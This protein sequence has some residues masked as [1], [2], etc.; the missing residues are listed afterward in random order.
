[1]ARGHLL[2]DFF[3]DNMLY[4]MSPDPFDVFSNEYVILFLMQRIDR[5]LYRQNYQVL[6][7]APKYAANMAQYDARL[8]L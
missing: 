4:S 2:E 8:F 6:F 1:M 5:I 7:Q 3:G